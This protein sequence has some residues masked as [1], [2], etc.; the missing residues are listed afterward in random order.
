MRLRGPLAYGWDFE[1]LAVGFGKQC[2]GL[3]VSSNLEIG[4][5]PLEDFSGEPGCDVSELNC[6]AQRACVLKSVSGFL[7]GDDRIDPIVPVVGAI[8]VG[9]A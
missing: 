5:I 8:D 3:R 1:P 7:A 6:F 4:R 9:N 2:R